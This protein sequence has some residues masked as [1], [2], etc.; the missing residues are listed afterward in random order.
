MLGVVL[1][2]QE[3]Y[4]D[5]VAE[6]RTAATDIHNRAPFGAWG[7]L[8]WAYLEMGRHDDAL[9]ALRSAVQNQRAFCLGYFLMG[10]VHLA[11]EDFGDAVAAFTNALEADGRC[12][13]IQSAW[14]HRGEAY[15]RLGQRDDAIRDFEECERLDERSEDGQACRRLLD[16]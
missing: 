7:N 14:R 11:R 1:M 8:G 9:A 13:G 12:I 16:H 3:R 5:A 6:L 4:D 10:R 15:A 2:N